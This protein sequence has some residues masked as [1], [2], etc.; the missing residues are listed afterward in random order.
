[1]KVANRKL[2]DDESGIELRSEDEIGRLVFNRLQIGNA[3]RP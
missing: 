1:L 3:V 2:I